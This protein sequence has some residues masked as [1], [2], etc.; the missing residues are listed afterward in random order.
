MVFLMYKSLFLTMII[1]VFSNFY[2]NSKPYAMEASG[3]KLNSVLPESTMKEL[4][5]KGEQ[6]L[7]EIYSAGEPNVSGYFNEIQPLLEPHLTAL[8]YSTKAEWLFDKMVRKFFASNDEN[9]VNSRKDSMAAI[10][11]IMWS[12]VEKA[13]LQNEFFERGSFTI[14]DQD[15]RLHNFLLDYVKLVTDSENPKDLPFVKT[16]SNFAYRRDPTLKGSSHHEGRCPESQFGIDIRENTHESVLRLLPFDYTHLLFAK[17]DLNGQKEPLLFVKLEPLGMG[18]IPATIVHGANFAH[19][20][21]HVDTK[22]RREKDI[23]PTIQD[24][25]NNLKNKANLNEEKTIRGMY[26]AA[27]NILNDGKILHDLALDEWVKG[28]DDNFELNDLKKKELIQDA[29]NFVSLLD[30]TYPDKKHH[31]RTGN[32]VILDF[33]A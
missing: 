19:S 32:E 11:C 7:K 29:Q 3:Q 15:Y 1:T 13:A 8:K 24:S 25:F 31:L 22:T 12:L 23:L 6:L 5:N 21:S 20:L 33:T 30:Q 28:F 18:S 10:V 9:Y 17:L 2:Q 26:L 14:I 27:H 16:M 4:L